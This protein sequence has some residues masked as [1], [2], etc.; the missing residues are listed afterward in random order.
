[1]SNRNP[2]PMALA[3]AGFVAAAASN[4]VGMLVV[5]KFF[6]NALLAVTDPAVFSWLGQVAIMLWGFAYLAVARGYHHVPFL[7]L[8]FCVEKIV[9]VAAWL[10]WLSTNRH[11][12]PQIEAVS[13]LTAGFFKAYGALDA[14]FALFFGVM[15]IIVRK[16]SRTD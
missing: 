2:H 1:M 3:T 9:Y 6:T 13:P 5:S 16:Q 11:T 8:V 4:I 12:L 14:L 7:L 15:F 10:M